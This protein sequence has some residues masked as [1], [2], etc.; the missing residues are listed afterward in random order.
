[1]VGAAEAVEIGLAHAAVPP[2]QLDQTVADLVGALL[3]PL[4][5]AVTETKA[6]LQGAAQ[7]DLE[8]QRRLEREAQVRRFRELA[9]GMTAQH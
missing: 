8:E 5:G 7:R 3:A 9:A 4:R 6:L 1:M 2:D